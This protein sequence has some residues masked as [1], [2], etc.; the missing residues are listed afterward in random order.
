MRKPDDKDLEWH[1]NNES[2]WLPLEAKNEKGEIE[3]NGYV[4]IR[5]DIV[6]AAYAE[7]NPVGSAREDPN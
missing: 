2:F 1:E 7:K 3:N 6:S 4:R 5:I